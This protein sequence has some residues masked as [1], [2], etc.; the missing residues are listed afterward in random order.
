MKLYDPFNGQMRV[1]GFMSGSGTNLRKIIETEKSFEARREKPP[2]HVVGIFTDNPGSKA[3]GIGRDYDLPVIVRDIGS[4]YRARKADIKDLKVRA[5][6]DAE[7]V[8]ILRPLQAHVA[9]YAGYMKAVT[10][11]LIDEF[12]GVNVHP[13]DLSVIES[14][15]RK[16]TGAHAVKNAI[17]AGEK[18]LR[19][20]T[21]IVE[22]K[23]DSGRVLMTSAP[24]EVE[25]DGVDLTQ[26]DEAKRVAE[27]H[28]DRLKQ[29]GDWVIF[30]KT[31]IHIADGRFSTDEQGRLYHDGK[32]IPNGI[33]L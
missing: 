24:L 12:L 26:A 33:S 11:P 1:V 7:T 29:I 6:F 32:L 15:K 30:P 18:F 25:I 5:E 16:Y 20:S 23:V 3:V 31:L 4:F 22:K 8:N 13:A 28:Q 19:A 27:E 17:L 9:A 14:E 2:Y 21:H 10:R